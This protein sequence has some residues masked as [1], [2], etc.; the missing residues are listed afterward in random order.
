MDHLTPKKKPLRLLNAE[1]LER[2][3]YLSGLRIPIEKLAPLFKNAA[4]QCLTKDALDE[5]ISRQVAAQNALE[6]G[7]ALASSNIKST[8]FQLA[9]G[10]ENPEAI[11]KK[12]GKWKERPDFR[13]LQYWCDTQ[14]GF[15]RTLAVEMSG[16]DGAPI[17]TQEVA[18]TKEQLAETMRRIKEALPDDLDDDE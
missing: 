9:S 18:L 5:I 10:E 16:V 6:K 8:L 15:K 4:G 3:Q 2:L 7:R 17:Q 12:K 11:Q 14:E 13:A 1:E